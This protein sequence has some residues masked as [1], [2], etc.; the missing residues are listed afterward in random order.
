MTKSV[1]SKERDSGISLVWRNRKNPEITVEAYD[2]EYE[3]REEEDH[4]QWYVFGALRGRGVPSSPEIVWGKGE[5]IRV[6]AR[7][8]REYKKF[9]INGLR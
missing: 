5:A 9:G 8:K 1:W 7:L 2:L 4:G 3:T 6:V